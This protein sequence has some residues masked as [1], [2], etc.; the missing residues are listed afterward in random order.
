MRE[1]VKSEY[2]A[3][4]PEEYAAQTAAEVAAMEKE[5]QKEYTGAL[6]PDVMG[7]AGKEGI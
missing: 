3:D 6:E 1:M 2:T 5:Q 4:M 7:F